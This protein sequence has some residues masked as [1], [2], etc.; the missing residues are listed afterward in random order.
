MLS[1]YIDSQK[2]ESKRVEGSVTLTISSISR[3]FYW[4]FRFIIR[5]FSPRTQRLVHKL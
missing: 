4:I 3:S 2:L 1:F 5:S